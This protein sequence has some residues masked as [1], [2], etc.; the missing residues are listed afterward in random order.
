MEF[1]LDIP[2]IRDILTVDVR[3]AEVFRIL[4]FFE[5]SFTPEELHPALSHGS[6]CAAA[7]AKS[8]RYNKFASRRGRHLMDRS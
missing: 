8:M 6:G 2:F 4:D 5:Q 7:A 1:T 3:A